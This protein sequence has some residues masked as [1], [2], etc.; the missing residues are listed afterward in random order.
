MALE[1]EFLDPNDKPA[2][3][4]INDPETLA[5]ARESLY[6]LEYKVHETASHESFLER[7]G[8]VPYQVVVIEDTFGGGTR[9]DNI[10]LKTLQ[11]MSMA[12]RRHSTILLVGDSYQTMS[13]MEAFQQSVHGVLNRVDLP[14]IQ[15]V[16][17]QVISDTAVFLHLYADVQ[18]RLAQGQR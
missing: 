18:V 12:V 10:S 2:L 7:F 6:Q 13:P 3:L 16:L 5:L 14:Q 15:V 17:R 11:A 9:E 8:Q 4:A 1:F